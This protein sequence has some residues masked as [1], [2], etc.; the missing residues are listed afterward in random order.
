MEMTSIFRKVTSPRSL[1]VLGLSL[2]AAAGFS[3]AAQ[4]VDYSVV[5]VPEE[6]GADFVKVT[7]TGDYVCMPQ[8]RRTRAGIT[9][10]S[11]RILGIPPGEIGRAHV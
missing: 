7:K 6:A 4:N 8:V 9:W 10:L 1:R 5:S 11:N 2:F 3:A